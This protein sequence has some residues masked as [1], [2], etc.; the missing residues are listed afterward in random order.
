VVN[1]EFGVNEEIFN[2]SDRGEGRE[3]WEKSRVNGGE[4]ERNEMGEGRDK[5]VK[6]RENGEK[7][8]TNDR[9]KGRDKWEKLRGNG[10]GN[11]R[12]VGHERKGLQMEN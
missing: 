6:S 9:G 7:N 8:E 1:E 5:W 12:H 4:N 11:G 3:K 10:G 2:E